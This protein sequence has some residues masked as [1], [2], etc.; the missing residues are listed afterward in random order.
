MTATH[1]LA[2]ILASVSCSA[3]GHLAVK[4]GVGRVELDGGWIRMLQQA[5]GNGWLTA[6][7]ALHVAALALWLV[8]LRRAELSFAAPFI[9]LSFV[10]VALLS[11]L[12]LHESFGPL[13]I[14]GTAL[15]VLGV[16][17]VSQS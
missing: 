7:L 16:V 5:L 11:W 14:A 13:R 8:A 2:A 3:F 15:V 4:I 17:L 10:V 12:F 1:S 9:A 6:G